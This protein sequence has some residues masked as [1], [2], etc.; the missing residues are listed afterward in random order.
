MK[1]TITPEDGTGSVVNV[2]TKKR[3][4]INIRDGGKDE[5]TVQ[6]SFDSRENNKVST[7]FTLTDRG[8]WALLKAM[9]TFRHEIFEP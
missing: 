3:Q 1:T 8:F 6:I 4:L 7:C 5:I 9:K 2:A